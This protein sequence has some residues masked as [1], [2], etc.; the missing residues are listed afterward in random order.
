MEEKVREYL[1]DKEDDIVG[2]LQNEDVQERVAETIRER[3][4]R[5]LQTPLI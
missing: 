1:K 2:W 4:L 5:Y 3:T